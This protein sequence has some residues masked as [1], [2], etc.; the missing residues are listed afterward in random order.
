[1]ARKSRG[2][3]ARKKKQETLIRKGEFKYRGYTLDE[4][5]EMPLKKF[6]ELLPARQR[7]SLLRSL[8]RGINPKHRKLL[9]KIRRARRLLNRGKEPKIIRT[10]CR[11]FII[12]PEMVGLTFGVY[13]GQ[14]FKE[15]KIVPEAI[16]RYLG[17]FSLTRKIVKHGAPGVG[18]TRGSM[19]VPIK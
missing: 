19:F 11:D 17:E 8:A 16:G 13:N 7:R 14:E 1:M 12:I 4:L 18:A 2:R 9:K 3:R 5:L 15:V 6:A 10:H